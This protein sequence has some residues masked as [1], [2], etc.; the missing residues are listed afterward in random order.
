MG[1]KG[2]FGPQIDVGVMSRQSAGDTRIRSN[3]ERMH[4]CEVHQIFERWSFLG[5]RHLADH[6][7]RAEGVTLAQDHL[8]HSCSLKPWLDQ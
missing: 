5:N 1:D 2:L 7:A 3:P 4:L 8:A 6:M